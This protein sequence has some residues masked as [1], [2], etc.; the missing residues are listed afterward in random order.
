M[1]LNIGSLLGHYDV[2]ALIGESGM[3][4]VYRA[5]DTKPNRDVALKVLC[6]KGYWDCAPGEPEEL[7]LASPALRFSVFE[8]ASEILY[9]NA[10]SA[11]FKRVAE[12]D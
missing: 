10:G 7:D 3:G 6:G 12:S 9:W 5:T 4:E 1:P 8:S 2:T 11:Q